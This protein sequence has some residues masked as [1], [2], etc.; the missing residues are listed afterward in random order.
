MLQKPL[1]GD[2]IERKD[3]VEDG[4]GHRWFSN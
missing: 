2:L 1:I 3:A 4:M